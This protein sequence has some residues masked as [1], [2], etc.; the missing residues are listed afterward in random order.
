MHAEVNIS[1]KKSIIKTLFFRAIEYSTSW[2]SLHHG[3]N[4]I[5]QT[6]IMDVIPLCIVDNVVQRLLG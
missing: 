1:Y 6:L 2:A 4:R 3:I 5:K